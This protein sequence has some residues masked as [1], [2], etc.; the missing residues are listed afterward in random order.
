MRANWSLVQRS[1]RCVDRPDMPNATPIPEPAGKRTPEAT[2]LALALILAA[3]SLV[4]GLGALSSGGEADPWYTALNKAPGNPPGFVFGIVWPILY[5]LMAVGAFMAWRAGARLGLF[6]VQLVLNFTWSFLFF[7]FHQPLAALV[8]LLALWVLV[9]T[10]IRQF[11]RASPVA[12]WMQAPYLAWLSF[13]AY[14][15][16]WVV[17][18]N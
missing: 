11:H 13:A 1:L 8:N 15:N 16:A 3:T 14:L 7:E 12:A 9:F 4:A 5:A 18:A 17:F 2:F 10:M 6:F